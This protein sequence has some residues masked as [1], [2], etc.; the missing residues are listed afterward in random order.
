VDHERGRCNEFDVVR[1]SARSIQGEL[2]LQ[3][4]EAQSSTLDWARVAQQAKFHRVHPLVHHTLQ[5]LE[6]VSLPAKIRAWFEETS[7]AAVAWNRFGLDELDA[8]LRLLER[9][10][11]QALVFKGPVFSHL[12]YGD[13]GLRH[14]VDLDVLIQPEHMSTV[15]EM[16]RDEEYRRLNPDSSPL[17]R[18]IRF[19]FQKEHHYARGEL[20]FNLDIHTAA[21]APTFNPGISFEGLYQRAQTVTIR[22]GRFRTPATED[23]LLLLCL[24]GAKDRWARLK[25]IC[26]IN[27]LTRSH[28]DLNWEAVLVR[29]RVA[30]CERI[31]ALGLHLARTVLDLPLPGQVRRFI[32]QHPL[33]IEWGN[34]LASRLPRRLDEPAWG[35]LRERVTYP[36]AIQDTPTG[37]VRYATYAAL[38]KLMSRIT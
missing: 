1:L 24:H 37:K 16:L 2:A 9:S 32:D 22:E 35:S 38:G 23:L 3:G 11:L 34:R 36:L 15:D 29:A 27:E 33:M 19:F 4:I 18:R 25:R 7:R 30:E 5:Q 8:I 13:A 21:V 10:G 6:C 20:V 28:P 14:S 31:V 12:A 26:D 17:R